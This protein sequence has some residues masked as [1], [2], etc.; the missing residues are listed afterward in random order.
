MSKATA[1]VKSPTADP[2]KASRKR[3][4][5]F[6][7]SQVLLRGSQQRCWARGKHFLVESTP[8]RGGELLGRARGTYQCLVLGFFS[9]AERVE[10]FVQG[11]AAKRL[12]VSCCHRC[13]LRGS[14]GWGAKGGGEKRFTSTELFA[15]PP[16]LVPREFL[17]SRASFPARNPSLSFLTLRVLHFQGIWEHHNHPAAFPAQ[18]TPKFVGKGRVSPVRSRLLW[19]KQRRNR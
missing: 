19:A 15:S 4:S 9:F 12:R 13:Q 18:K 10:G 17:L 2:Q 7:A 11:Q 5:R 6:Q 3:C 8:G 14:V 16:S 1:G